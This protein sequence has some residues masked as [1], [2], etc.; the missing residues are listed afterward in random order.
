VHVT[1]VTNASRT[2]LLDLQTFHWDDELLELF[3][4]DRAV[5]PR[6]AASCGVVGE[7][8]VLGATLP[9][10]GIAGDQQAALFG[11]AC[12]SPGQAKTTYGTGSFVL[13][14]VGD[15]GEPAPAGL[16]RRP[17][18]SARAPARS[19]P[20]RAPCSP[21]APPSSGSATAWA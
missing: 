17:R 6:V 18:P 20:S 21:A 3:H 12:F 9:V 19:T 2:M 1:D 10:A 11:Q 8:G 14:N 16:P 5:L 13:V 7:A 15:S 4:V